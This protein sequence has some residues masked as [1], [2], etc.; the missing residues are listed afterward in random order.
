MNSFVFHKLYYCYKLWGHFNPARMPN[1]G[2]KLHAENRLP[3]PP[4]K[5]NNKKRSFKYYAW[6]RVSHSDILGL[7]WGLVSSR[8]EYKWKHQCSRAGAHPMTREQSGCTSTS[9]PHVV[10]ASTALLFST[11]PHAH[12]AK[13]CN[14][15]SWADVSLQTKCTRTNCFRPL[16]SVYV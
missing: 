16:A 11:S 5:E 9:R 8:D 2:V 15:I 6:L 1:C 4:K 3:P 12:V 13:L 10:A 14:L 7:G